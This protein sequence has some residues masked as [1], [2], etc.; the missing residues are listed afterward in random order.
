MCVPGGAF[1]PPRSSI[2]VPR[3]WAPGCCRTGAPRSGCSR[4]PG[5]PAFP[6]LLPLARTLTK[7]RRSAAVTVTAALAG[8]SFAYGTYLLTVSQLAL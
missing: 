6:L 8:L 2:T 3:W 5:L 1:C 7:A 4:L